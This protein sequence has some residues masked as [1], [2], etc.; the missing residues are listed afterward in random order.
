MLHELQV[1]QIELE[2]QN[3]ELRRAQQELEASRARYFD[4]YDLAPVGYL[5]LS[6]QGLILEA[7]LTAATLLGVARDA[8]VKQP[9]SRFILPEDQ[10]IYY[11][12]RKQLFETGAPQV[13]ELRMVSADAAPF[14]AR[15]EAA[16][17]QGADGV[18]VC[19]AVVSDITER[20]RAEAALQ[21][22]IKEL[23][24]LY[25]ISALLELPG[26]SLDEILKRTVLLIPPAWQFPEITAACIEVAGQSF[27]TARFRETPWMQGCV[28]IANGEPV[29]QV[30]VCYL[31]DRPV[32]H[33]GPFLTEERYLLNAIA[34]RLGRVVE[35]VRAEEALKE[36]EERFRLAIN[37]TKD[38]LWEWDIQ[39]NQEFFSPRWCEIVGYSFDDPELPHTFNSWASR[40]HPDDYDR[41]LSTLSN[42][43]EKGGTYDVDYRH[44][45]KSGEYRWQNSRG[46]A[47]FD[48]SGKP[49]KMVGCISDITERKRAA[50]ALQ[51]AHDELE[52]RVLERTADLVLANEQLTREIEERKQSEETLRQSELRYKKLSQ[53]FDVLLNAIS[54]T[55]VLLSPEMKVLWTNNGS[56]YHAD[57]PLAELIGQCCYD[58]FYGRSAPCE[59]CPVVR[60]FHTGK[61]EAQV[62]SRSGRFLDKRAYPIKDGDQVGSVIL[63]VSDITEKMSL[64]AEAMQANHLASLGEL[65]AGVAHEINNPINGIINY[66]QILINECGP[67]SLE[68][69]IAAGLSR[70]ATA[71]PVS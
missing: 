3:E 51:K 2:M 29:G 19:R 42:H 39:T 46:Q 16:R 36:S 40:I 61:A 33:E 44:R 71:S 69:D 14:W 66:A 64:Q 20:K 63:L 21:E 68:N 24:C 34:E 70:R 43:L 37:A 26:I 9:L 31:E 56:A 54:D 6:E 25:G 35:R 23:T 32:T 28:I 55:L 59:D 8:L 22:R 52:K 30:K 48:E 7:N 57:A 15:L 18:S 58:L 4:L 45:H 27:Q 67:E 60:S 47:C 11:R 65:A 10:D 41:V 1:H 13:C 62:S 49:T 50:E 5:T 53:E 17:T 38:G 12:H